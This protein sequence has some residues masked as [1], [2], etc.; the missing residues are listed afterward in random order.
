MYGAG[1]CPVMYGVGMKPLLNAFAEDGCWYG[2]GKLYALLGPE[3]WGRGGAGWGVDQSF[4]VLPER[5]LL[6]VEKFPDSELVPWVAL[7]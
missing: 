4:S 3:D 7:L 6:G 2:E 5:P 1:C